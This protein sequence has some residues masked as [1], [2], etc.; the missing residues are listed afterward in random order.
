MSEKYGKV[1]LVGA[2]PGDPGLLTLRGREVLEAANVVV[3]DRLVGDG[4]LSFIPEHAE[5]INA[6]KEGGRHPVPQAEI[7]SILI[8]EASAGKN[9]VRLKGGDPFLFGRGG[10]EIEA[11]NAHGIRYEVVPGI[12]SAIAAPSAAGIPV[13]HRG[14]AASLHIITAHTKEGGIADTDYES[15]TKLGGTLVF[16]MGASSVPEICRT[17]LA[18]GMSPD[19]PVAAVENGTTA[20]Q[21]RLEAPLR[22]FEDTCAKARLQSPS[23]IVV[24]AVAAL[25]ETFDWKRFLPL[26]GLRVLVTRPRGRSDKLSR[27]LRD[28]GAEV[29][30]LPCIATKTTSTILPDLSD[31]KWVGFTSAT[32]VKS[33]FELLEKHGRDV[34]E[35]NG[36]KIAAIGEVTARELRSRGLKV[37]FV[38]DVYDGVNLAKG[39]AEIA[40]GSKIALL[41]AKDGSRELT[42]YLSDCGADFI[43]IPV[44]ETSYE[45]GFFTPS[46]IDAALFTSAST[47][48][49]FAALCPVEE[50]GHACC[51]GRQ[52]AEAAKH[53][54]FRNIR[55]AEKATLESLIKTLEG[56]EHD[57]QTKETA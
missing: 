2:G 5:K 57:N 56:V 41:R 46:G 37:N 20:A 49:G 34:R 8:R 9:V 7:E 28:K 30:E 53:A 25:G 10:E 36:A 19:T 23:V 4:I 1:W 24:G 38:P 13:T 48:R 35:I 26:A 31:A 43:E 12:T 11:L 32:G 40:D 6:G 54:G 44:Y 27:M 18:K 22:D 15:L 55:V 21:R 16:L 47:V 50:V 3:F 45:S 33:F 29:V 14:V 17:L 42:E 39:L 52:T 51:I